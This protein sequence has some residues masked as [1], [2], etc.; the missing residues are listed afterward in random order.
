MLPRRCWTT[1]P[2]SRLGCPSIDTGDAEF[3]SHFRRG[4][5]HFVLTVVVGLCADIAETI[6]VLMGVVMTW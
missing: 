2:L 4:G 6:N 5:A 3:Q 1:W